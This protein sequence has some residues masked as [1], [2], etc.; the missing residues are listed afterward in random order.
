M[1]IAI[2]IVSILIALLCIAAG[3]AKVVLVP[4]EVEF[5]SGFGLSEPMIISFGLFQ[6]IGGALFIIPKTLRIGSCM[7]AIGFALSAL[8]ILTTGNILFF[9]VS[10]LPA[11]IAGW[12][13]FD[14]FKST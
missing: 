11:V 1:K 9:A 6:V 14:S 5:L 13:A 2:K 10:C 4:Q 7:V 12:F 8:L 3:F